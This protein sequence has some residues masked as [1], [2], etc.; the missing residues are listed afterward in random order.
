ME[1]TLNI[2]L[3]CFSLLLLVLIPSEISA[4]TVPS[5]PT[6][7]TA[8]AISSTQINLFWNAPS[9]DGASPITGYKIEYKSGSGSYS[10]LST[11]VDTT[12]SHTGL[13]TGTVYTY[14]VSAINSVGTSTASSEISVT[15]TSSSTGSLPNSPTNLSGYAS[16]PTQATLFWS[17]PTNNGGYPI[18]GYKIEYRIN[19]GS[20]TELI[21]NTASTS[22]TYSH[23]GLSTNSVYTYRVYAITSFGTSSTSSSEVVVQPKST[24]TTT[25]PGIPTNLVSTAVSSTQINLFWSAP[26]NNGGSQITGYKIEYKSGSGAY[27]TLTTT[28]NTSYSHTG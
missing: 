28:Q 21:S 1:K 2:S 4:A 17:A 24:S 14:K 19:S 15:P 18:I 8:T 6:D 3:A 13:T 9:N 23:T 12:F 5:S 7:V 22:T 20:Y 16:S 26:T 27:S 25:V 10:V 11:T